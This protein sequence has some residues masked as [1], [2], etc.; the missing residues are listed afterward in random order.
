MLGHTLRA[1]C[2]SRT[3]QE[4]EPLERKGMNPSNRPSHSHH[5]GLLTPHRGEKHHTPHTGCVQESLNFSP[6]LEYENVY[7]VV[8]CIKCNRSR[9]EFKWNGLS[10]PYIALES[11]WETDGTIRP[12][13]I[14]L[15]ISLVMDQSRIGSDR[16]G[17]GKT[18][19]LEI[20]SRSF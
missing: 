17:N 20:E 16:T 2:G 9:L 3:R 6:I 7:R 10:N 18:I 13:P 4:R 11:V 8:K 1:Y 19:K 14:A 5:S 15:E 12:I